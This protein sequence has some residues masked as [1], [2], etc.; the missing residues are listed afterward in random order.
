MFLFSISYKTERLVMLSYLIFFLSYISN[1][2]KLKN[3]LGEYLAWI[4]N[5]DAIYRSQ[6]E[7]EYKEHLSIYLIPTRA[8]E[9]R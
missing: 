5:V 9:N 4:E 7:C 2:R 3:V 6:I 8:F 1:P